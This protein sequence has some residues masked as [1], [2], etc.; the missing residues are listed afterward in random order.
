MYLCLVSVSLSLPQE[1]PVRDFSTLFLP[2]EY[3]NRWN[4]LPSHPNV[5]IGVFIWRFQVVKSVAVD[6]SDDKIISFFKKEQA[7]GLLPEVSTPCLTLRYIEFPTLNS[8]KW[9]ASLVCSFWAIALLTLVGSNWVCRGIKRYSW[10]CRWRWPCQGQPKLNVCMACVDLGRFVW[11]QV[12]SDVPWSCYALSQAHVGDTPWLVTALIRAV[13]KPSK[14]V[15]LVVMIWICLLV[16]LASLGDSLLT[17]EIQCWR[18]EIY[19]IWT[20][21]IHVQ[22]FYIWGTNIANKTI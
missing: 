21:A 2:L 11:R 19:T 4:I 10:L 3:T 13:W 15:K 1:L 18:E 22:L 9:L 7:I 17:L 12:L 14:A 5:Q 16:C 20:D 8:I 6:F